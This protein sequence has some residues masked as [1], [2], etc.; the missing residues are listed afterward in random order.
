MPVVRHVVSEMENLIQRCVICGE[1]IFNY[2][3]GMWDGEGGAPT[4]FAAG[5]L[6]VQGKN[7]TSFTQMPPDGDFVECS[8]KLK[9]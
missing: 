6:F 8:A 7:P 5:E 9:E 2:Q 1:E 3:G 4:G